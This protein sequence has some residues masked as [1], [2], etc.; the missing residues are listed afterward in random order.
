MDKIGIPKARC[1]DRRDGAEKEV[2]FGRASY[3]VRTHMDDENNFLKLLEA[4]VV[5]LNT[6]MAKEMQSRFGRLR[7]GPNP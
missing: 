5:R 1:I 2:P 4:R 7:G 3:L 6:E